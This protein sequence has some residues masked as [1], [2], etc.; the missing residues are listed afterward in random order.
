MKLKRNVTESLPIDI[1]QSNVET[2]TT[3]GK[4]YDYHKI[5]CSIVW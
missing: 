5:K 1:T 4:C 3:T 2:D